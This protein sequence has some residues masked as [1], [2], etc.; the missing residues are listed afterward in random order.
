MDRDQAVDVRGVVGAKI[1]EDAWRIVSRRFPKSL[2][3]LAERA[4]LV[5]VTGCSLEVDLDVPTGVETQV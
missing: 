2:I 3:W 5:V 1:I 4:G